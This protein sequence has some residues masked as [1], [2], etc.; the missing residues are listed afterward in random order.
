M[1]DDA[2]VSFRDETFGFGFEHPDTWPVIPNILGCAA[3]LVEPAEEIT[4]F[5]ANVAIAIEEGAGHDLDALLESQLREIRRR[6]TDYTV[7]EQQELELSGCP[8][9]YVHGTYREGIFS[10]HLEQWPVSTPHRV[11]ALTATSEE[12]RRA[13][14]HD[15]IERV[16][17]S[18]TVL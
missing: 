4:E 17:N 11:V 9:R 5:R 8:A 6:F 12:A 1:A 2:W 3:L 13:Q 18:F 10:I 15:I 7:I 14:V 16:V